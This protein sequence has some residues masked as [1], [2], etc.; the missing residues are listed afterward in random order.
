MDIFNHNWT[1][2]MKNDPFITKKLNNYPIRDDLSYRIAKKVI[3]LKRGE[4]FK[5]KYGTEYV[6]YNP[7]NVDI[8]KGN[9]KPERQ[10]KREWFVGNINRRDMKLDEEYILPGSAIHHKITKT[11]SYHA[12]TRP[13]SLYNLRYATLR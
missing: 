5:V 13:Q 2:R 11:E 9:I 7:R 10:A 1:E 4:L 6:P 3:S 8:Y 12:N